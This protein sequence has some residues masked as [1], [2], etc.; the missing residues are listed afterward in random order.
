[1]DKFKISNSSDGSMTAIYFVCAALFFLIGLAI[2]KPMEDAGNYSDGL[3]FIPV[4]FLFIGLAIAY[5]ISLGFITEVDYDGNVIRLKS[6]Y[7]KKEIDLSKV[8]YVS[9][10]YVKGY[11]RYAVDTIRIDFIP[12]ETKGDASVPESLH[13]TV[14]R[15]IVDGLMKGNYSKF[16]LMQMY[17][18]IIERYPEKKAEES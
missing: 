5:L 17:Q 12:F 9:Y 18:D 4:L 3:I 11:G 2:I 1:M 16:P 8:K 15:E 10:E 14:T 7:S 6:F 13:E